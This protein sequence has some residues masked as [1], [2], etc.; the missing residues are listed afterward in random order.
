MAMASIERLLGEDELVQ[1]AKAVLAKAMESLHSELEQVRAELSGR[2]ASLEKSQEVGLLRSE[3]SLMSRLQQQGEQTA[4]WQKG[5]EQEVSSYLAKIIEGELGK[6]LDSK[7]AGLQRSFGAG[8]V[9]HVEKAFEEK[10]KE[11]QERYETDLLDKMEKRFSSMIHGLVEDRA[12]GLQ[13]AYEKMNSEAAAFYKEF[14]RDYETSLAKH[15]EAS[16][17]QLKALLEGMPRPEVS[18]TVPANS[19]Q[20]EQL[21][22][23]VVLPDRAIQVSIDQRLS[24]PKRKSVVTKSVLY[25]PSSGRPDKV[26]E[27]TTEETVN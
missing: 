17:S 8:L 14:Y 16:H 21:P 23:Q 22:S 18:V 1:V 11:I 3:K 9:A 7:I 5:Q 13:Q 20:I 12:K 25:D 19:I 26:V 10:V 27:E 4:A 6:A 24:M 15:L 2:L